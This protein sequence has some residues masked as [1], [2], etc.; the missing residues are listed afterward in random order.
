MIKRLS[1]LIGTGFQVAFI[2]WS[3]KNV[4][5]LVSFRMVNGLIDAKAFVFSTLERVI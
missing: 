5:K 2:V 1:T 4:L 3:F